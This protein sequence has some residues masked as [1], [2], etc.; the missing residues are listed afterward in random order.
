MTYL[1][2]F[3]DF[4]EACDSLVHDRVHSAVCLT[5]LAIFALLEPAMGLPRG[6]LPQWNP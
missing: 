6:K 1:D 4:V 5:Y 2:P 3:L